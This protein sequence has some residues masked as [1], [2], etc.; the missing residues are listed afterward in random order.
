MKKIVL[1]FL[2]TLL[3]ISGITA[4]SD[5]DGSSTVDTEVY[6]MTHKLLGL[7]DKD[8]G[9]GVE[10]ARIVFPMMERGAIIATN[11]RIPGSVMVFTK[12]DKDIYG[13][14]FPLYEHFPYKT[15][16]PVLSTNRYIYFYQDN[17]TNVLRVTD[18]TEC[19]YDI[20]LGYGRLPEEGIPVISYSAVA[21]RVGIDNIVTICGR[22]TITGFAKIDLSQLLDIEFD[23][24]PIVNVQIEVEQQPTKLIFAYT[25]PVIDG[26]KC[27]IMDSDGQV[28]TP[29]TISWMLTATLAEDED[30]E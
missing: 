29:V 12:W 7:T 8:T 6:P 16:P 30:D 26:F 10:D 2:L 14:N 4:L 1:P 25:E 20:H 27:Y 11:N 15:N 22:S 21:G 24:I 23:D 9:V 18:G 5:D 17:G 3:V 19:Y 28:D 13:N